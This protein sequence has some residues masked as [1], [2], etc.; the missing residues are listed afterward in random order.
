M[1]RRVDLIVIHCSATPND[2]TLFS[3]S[4]PSLRTPLDEIDAWHRQR[5]FLRSHPESAHFN[6]RHR[7]VGYH[8]IIARNGAVFTGRHEDEVGAHAA[9]FNVSSIG[10]CLVGTDAY[11]PAQWAWLKS[12]VPTIAARH[13][14]PLQMPAREVDRRAGGPGYREVNGICGHR[15]LS[16]DGNGNGLVEPFEWLKTCPGFSVGDWLAGGMEPLSG[17]VTQE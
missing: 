11:T 5:R 16:P 12:T 10:I 14:V 15:D 8:F 17:H 9:S 1:P 13:G 2:R 7:S 4:G 3:G 6:P